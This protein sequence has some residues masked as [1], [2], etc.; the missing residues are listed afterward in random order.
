MHLC[1][2][3]V[4]YALLY[5][6]TGETKINDTYLLSY[7]NKNFRSRVV[8]VVILTVAIFYVKNVIL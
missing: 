3:N 7:K 1:I 5:N 4:R 8:C 6:Y 2:L